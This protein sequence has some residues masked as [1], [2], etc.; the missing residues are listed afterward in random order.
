MLGIYFY[1]LMGPVPLAAPFLGWLC[2]VGGTELAFEV[3][4]ASALAVTALGVFA[5]T[6]PAPHTSPRKHAAA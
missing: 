5:V 1:A 6:R 4:G 3:A 2:S